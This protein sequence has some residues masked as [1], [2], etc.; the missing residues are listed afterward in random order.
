MDDHAARARQL[1]TLIS[2]KE[3]Q[4]NRIKGW[5][6]SLIQGICAACLLIIMGAG[7]VYLQTKIETVMLAVKHVDALKTQMA[8][9]DSREQVTTLTDR[10]DQLSAAKERLE[11]DVVQVEED[12]E[13]L[14]IKQQEKIIAPKPTKVKAPVRKTVSTGPVTPQKASKETPVQDIQR[15]VTQHSASASSSS[16]KTPTGE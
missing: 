6:T 1:L 12:L 7:F 14:K 16:D 9:V 15:E 5:R 10:M 11:A 4:F 2:K 13:T 3:E 8:A